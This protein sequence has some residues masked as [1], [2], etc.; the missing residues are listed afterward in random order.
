M[1]LPKAPKVPEVATPAARQS[2]QQP[3]RPARDRS[4]DEL[5]RRR[6]GFGALM[7]NG[8]AELQPPMTTTTLGG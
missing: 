6:R 1:C 3:E 2:T 7:R 5:A 8:R 4:D